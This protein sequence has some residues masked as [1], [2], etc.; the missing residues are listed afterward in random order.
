LRASSDTPRNF[1]MP[2]KNVTAR[3]PEPDG[4]ARKLARA[5][6]DGFAAAERSWPERARSTAFGRGPDL[7]A[8]RALFAEGSVSSPRPRRVP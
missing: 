8:S 6:R 1:R 3:M 2:T 7:G 4:L 5:T